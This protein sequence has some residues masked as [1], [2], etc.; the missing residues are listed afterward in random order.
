M[1]QLTYNFANMYCPKEP[2]SLAISGLIRHL[3]ND[4][5]KKL[6]NDETSFEN[7]V[8]DIP[9][10]MASLASSNYEIKSF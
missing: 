10:V 1:N 2:D 4:E 9:Q 6:L 5:L 3:N 7:V 8:K